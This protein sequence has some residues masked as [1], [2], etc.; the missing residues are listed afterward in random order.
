MVSL[1]FFIEPVAIHLD[2]WAWQNISIPVQNYW[3]WFLISFALNLFILKAKIFTENKIVFL[4]LSL[5][6]LFFLSHII[7]IEY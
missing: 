3:G 5:Q 4:M 2:F 7:K 6:V 1:D